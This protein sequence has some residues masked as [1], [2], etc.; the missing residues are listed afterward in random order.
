M[1]AQWFQLLI[2]KCT[3]ILHVNFRFYY[4]LRSLMHTIYVIMFAMLYL[5][6]VNTPCPSGEWVPPW[7]SGVW[8]PPW[9]SG[10]WVPLWLSAEWLPPAWV[11]SE[12]LPDWVVCEYLPDWVLCEWLPPWP[13]AEWVP[14]WGVSG[15]LPDWVASDYPPD[16]VVSEYLPAWAVC[17]TWVPGVLRAVACWLQKKH[18]TNPYEINLMDELTLKGVTQYYAFVQE[19]Q[20]VHCL[21]TLFSKVSG[22]QQCLMI[23]KFV[24]VTRF[25]VLHSLHWLYIHLAPVTGILA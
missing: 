18:L 15:Y 12:Y 24:T 23:G 16:W 14:P 9:L 13:S 2:L 5:C 3:I 11:V 10:E 7:L 21:N 25:W 20:K 1:N 8:V 6:W 19:K 4:I 17:E 22:P